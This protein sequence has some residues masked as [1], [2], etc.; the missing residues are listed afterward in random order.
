MPSYTKL[1]DSYTLLTGLI[2]GFAS[3]A[4]GIGGGVVMIPAMT[5]LLGYGIKKAIGTS[6]AVMIVASLVGVASHYAINSSNLQ[7]TVALWVIAGSLAGAYFGAR[8]ANKA[9]STALARAFGLLLIFVA[10][11]MFGIINIPTAHITEAGEPFLLLLGLVA[12]LSSALLGIGGGVLIVPVFVL[13]FGLSMHEAVPTSL[14]AIVPTSFVGA[15]FHKK[16]GNMDVGAL[17]VLLPAAFVGA[18]L[19]AVA[20]NRVP[21]ETLKLAFAAFMLFS[22][23]KLLVSKQEEN[24]VRKNRPE[25]E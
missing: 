16:F 12:G 1:K 5:L 15:F 11:K 19:G 7:F 24:P 2:A 17:K 10:L 8:I 6:L 25:K 3:A 21:S 18:I 22:S 23:V 13:F 4:L 9:S 20:A 14:M